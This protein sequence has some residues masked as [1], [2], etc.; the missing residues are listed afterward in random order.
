MRL[1]HT[2]R[3]GDVFRFDIG[4]DPTVILC[5]YDDIVASSRTEALL[6][7][8]Y[9]NLFPFI[10]VRGE[11]KKNT[12]TKLKNARFPQQGSL[13]WQARTLTASWPECSSARVARG[14]T[15]ASSP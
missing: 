10:D 7:K 5:D 9:D 11:G 14:G 3:Y 1:F 4:H 15:F 13:N 6:G 2:K 12:I 8:P